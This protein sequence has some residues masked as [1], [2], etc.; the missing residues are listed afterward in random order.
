MWNRL[1]NGPHCRACDA[2]MDLIAD[3]PAIGTPYGLKVYTC[4]GCGACKDLLTS[5]PSKAA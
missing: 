1:L 3:V 2:E 5:Q 4:P